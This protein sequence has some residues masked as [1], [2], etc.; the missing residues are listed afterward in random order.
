MEGLTQS[1]ALVRDRDAT[2]T[3][4]REQGLSRY[5]TQAPENAVNWPIHPFIPS[6]IQQVSSERTLCLALSWQ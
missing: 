1:F 4:I 6:F 5:P 2:C 3:P